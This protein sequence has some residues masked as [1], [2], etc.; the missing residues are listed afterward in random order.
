MGQLWFPGLE[1]LYVPGQIAA[2]D[3]KLL[4]HEPQL[5]GHERLVLLTNGM[6]GHMSTSDIHAALG[7]GRRR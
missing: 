6:I 1:F 7:R 3:G 2:D 4:V 5:D